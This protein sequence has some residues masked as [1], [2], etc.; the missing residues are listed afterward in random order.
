MKRDSL[1]KRI[2][3][4]EH[5][6]SYLFQEG[7]QESIVFVHGFGASKETFLEAFQTPKFQSFSMLAPDLLGFGDSDKPGSFS[8]RLKEQAKVIEST[9]DLI[10]VD[11]FHLVAHS[12]GGIIGIELGEMIPNRLRSFI[13]IEG[14]LTAEDCTMSMRVAEMG[15][16]H[17]TREGFE[18]LKHSISM[19]AKKTQNKP[20]GDYLRSLS[21]ATPTSLYR[22]SIS[23]VHESDHGNLLMRFA[24]LPVYKCYI[25]G[26]KNRGLFPA[27]NM[28]KQEEIPV[29]YVSESGHSMMNENPEEFYDLILRVIQQPS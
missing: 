7:G 22:S 5:I 23:T 21:K 17:F 6:V 4:N 25:Y 1:A 18:E 26:E 19:E 3:T 16:K 29:Y 13:N 2:K 12:M 14:N 10:G 28:L 27:E 20:L 11:R 9:I 15:E 8:Y 24:R